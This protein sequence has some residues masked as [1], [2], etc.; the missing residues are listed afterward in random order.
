MTVA[1]GL[2]WQKFFD[3]GGI[4]G[5]L[6]LVWQF[7]REGASCRRRPVLRIEPFDPKTGLMT[8]ADQAGESRKFVTL[9][10]SNTRGRAA[11]RCV[12][13]LRVIKAP[14]GV[15]IRQPSFPLH[16]A[17]V[18]YTADNSTMQPVDIGSEG[19]RLDVAFTRL[20][21]TEPGCWVAMPMSLVLPINHQGLLAPG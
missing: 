8:W 6:A 7:M 11:I 16:W 5:M 3:A 15:G 14:V 20:G 18:P 10:V 17:D 12:A 4:A 13:T 2:D 19:R 1:T 9:Q 21:Q